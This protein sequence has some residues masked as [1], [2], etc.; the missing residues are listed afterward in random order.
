MKAAVADPLRPRAGWASTPVYGGR[1][2]ARARGDDGARRAGRG[3]GDAAARPGRPAAARPAAS[4]APGCAT[5]GSTAG[6]GVTLADLPRLPFTTKQDLW[7]AYPL[8][9]LAV[10]LEDVVAMHGSSGSSG[11]PTLVG[12]TSGDLELWA[13]MCAR[14]LACAGA[15]PGSVVHNAYGVRPVHRRHRHPPGRRRSA[16]PSFRCPAADRAAGAHDR[17][18][19]ARHPAP[20]LPPTPYGSARRPRAGIELPEGGLFGSEPW[21][22]ELRARIEDVL[23][24]RALDIYGLSEIIGP[25]VAA[26]CLGGRGLHVNEDHFLVEAVEP[27]RRPVP[28]GIARRAGVQHA[29]R[30]DAAAA[31]PHRRHRLAARALRVRPDAR[32]DEQGARPQRR[33]AG[34]PRRERLPERDRGRRAAGTP[35]RTTRWSSTGASRW[36]GSSWRARTPPTACRPRCPASCGLSLRRRVLPGRDG[37]AAWRSARRYAS[38]TWTSGAPPIPGL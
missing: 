22:E 33:H 16:R 15:G 5:P 11:R 7:D 4:R 37:P 6:A 2:R 31:L 30:G 34:D 23:G 18:P 10:P 1:V 29:P 28:E 12:Y 35:R 36:R 27:R 24:L 25:G 32:A 14:S 9:M 13:A 3:A 38:S 8:G 20:A 19:A 21:S 26:E 17:R